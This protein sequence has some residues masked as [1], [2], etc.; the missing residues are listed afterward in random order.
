ML[1]H[2]AFVALSPSEVLLQIILS[3]IFLKV[4]T[5]EKQM[6]QL[7]QRMDLKNFNM[8]QINMVKQKLILLFMKKD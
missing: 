6:H 1:P 2:E 5:T 4:A 3:A 7:K 8:K